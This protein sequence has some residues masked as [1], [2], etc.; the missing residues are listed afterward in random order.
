[1]HVKRYFGMTLLLP[2]PATTHTRSTCQR[3]L[4]E[5]GD[6]DP[7]E[8]CRAAAAAASMSAFEDV[9]CMVSFCSAIL[10]AMASLQPRRSTSASSKNW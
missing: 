1:M 6:A 2:S 4:P 8:P 3:R 10:A 9:L 7:A 5:R